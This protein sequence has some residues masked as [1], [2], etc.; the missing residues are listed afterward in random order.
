MLATRTKQAYLLAA[1][2]PPV[3][4][5]EKLCFT[6]YCHKTSGGMQVGAQTKKIHW[7]VVFDSEFILLW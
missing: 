7:E 1:V 2:S 6:V 4:A 3:H 5:K